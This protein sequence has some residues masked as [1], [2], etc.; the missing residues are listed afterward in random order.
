MTIESDRRQKLAIALANNPL[1]TELF[2][3]LR[4]QTIRQWESSADAE[5][6]INAWNKIRALNEIRTAINNAIRE[7]AKQ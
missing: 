6:Q 2:E 3:D 7:D 5:I 1:L 4:V